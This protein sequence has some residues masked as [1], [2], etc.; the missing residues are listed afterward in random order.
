MNPDFADFL[1]ALL[2]ARARFLVVGA[3]AL[4]VHGVPRATGDIDIWIER[5]PENAARVWRALEEF[6]APAAALGV[7]Q[8][9]FEA[10][11]M[12][13]QIGL[14]PRRIDILTGV[15]GL[16]FE[17]AWTD[18]VEHRVDGLD[19]PFLGREALIRN[20][21]A[22]GRFKDLGDLEA[23]GEDPTAS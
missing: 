10:Q 23:L 3:H 19:V 8:A 13:V 9:D 2:A 17:T 5:S 14:P 4:A 22:S 11:D 20:K 15:S 12:V 21:R 1:A 7:K 6:G 16:T 18:R